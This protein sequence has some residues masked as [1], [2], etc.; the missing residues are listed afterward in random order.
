MATQPECLHRLLVVE[1]RHRPAVGLQVRH[2]EWSLTS[3]QQRL[4][5]AG[6]GLLPTGPFP[7]GHGENSWFGH[8]LSLILSTGHFYL[9][10]T[11]HSQMAL[12]KSFPV[13]SSH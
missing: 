7:L 10:Q 9:A 4:V 11:R 13:I 12:T 1:P 3:L 8:L 2:N 6:A 5:K